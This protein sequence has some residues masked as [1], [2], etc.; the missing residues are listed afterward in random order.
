MVDEESQFRSHL[1]ALLQEMGEATAQARTKVVLEASQS[2]TVRSSMTQMRLEEIARE[3]LDWL[4]LE[5][6]SA[7]DHAR[8]RGLATAAIDHQIDS[9]LTNGVNSLVMQLQAGARDLGEYGARV[10]AMGHQKARAE[11]RLARYRSGYLK[12]TTAKNSG[13]TYS[14][15]ITSSP[16]ANANQ[17]GSY[18]TQSSEV[19][20]DASAAMTALDKLLK[21][22]SEL[23]RDVQGRSEAEADIHSLRLQLQRQQP[24]R[25]LLQALGRS[26]RSVMEGTLAGVL[27]APAAEAASHLWEALG[28][29]G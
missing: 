29:S 7:G 19:T 17:L 9:A 10:S 25:T 4:L 13:S 22:L 2:G 18:V 23:D 15:S 20:L 6:V 8:S 11:T 26:V 21:A 27:A 14:I 12:P 3:Q 24:D 1:T 16:G 5:L 28:I